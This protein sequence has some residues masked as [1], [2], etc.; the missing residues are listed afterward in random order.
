[1]RPSS[2][3]EPISA[4]A[5]I[6]R[7]ASTSCSMEVLCVPDRLGAG[8]ALVDRE[9][10]ARAERLADRLRLAIVRVTSSRVGGKRQIS[11]SV[12]WVS[13]LTGLKLTLP[14]SF[15]QISVRMSATT[16]ALKPA[17]VKACDSAATRGVSY[18]RFRPSEKRLPSIW[19]ITP[20]AA[21]SA[22]G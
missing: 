15:V 5:S 11:S 10:K 16:G 18:C 13:A 3:T 2:M 7:P 14:Q 4:S 21:I 20:G 1:M 9:A 22:A 8:D 17:R 12:A 6:A 19:L